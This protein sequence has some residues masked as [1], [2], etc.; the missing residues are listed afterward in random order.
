M[1][2]D[3]QNENLGEEFKAAAPVA[4]VRVFFLGDTGL[5]DPPFQAYLQSLFIRE[6]KSSCV[7]VHCM[8]L[9]PLPC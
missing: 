5:T 6:D 1:A 7:Q 8:K 9:A 3:L 2:K 4:W